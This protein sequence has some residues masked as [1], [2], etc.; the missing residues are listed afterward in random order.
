MRKES[1]TASREE[2]DFQLRFPTVTVCAMR[3]F[4]KMASSP[5]DLPPNHWHPTTGGRDWWA[6]SEGR[7]TT[8]EVDYLWE[9][10]TYSASELVSSIQFD[11]ERGSLVLDSFNSSGGI[12]VATFEGSDGGRLVAA[13]LNSA[14]YGRCVVVRAEADI[15][16]PGNTALIVTLL[17]APA[18]AF[19]SEDGPNRLGVSTDY[20]F[21]DF[22]TMSAGTG[23][24]TVASLAKTVDWSDPVATSCLESLTA[25]GQSRCMEERAKAELRKGEDYCY[26]PQNRFLTEGLPV[27]RT[28]E[29]MSN[30]TASIVGALMAARDRGLCRQTCNFERFRRSLRQKPLVSSN[31][32]ASAGFAMYYGSGLV[33]KSRQLRLY[34][35]NTI[36]AAVGGSMG[37]FLGFSC[38]D[39][40]IRAVDWLVDRGINVQEGC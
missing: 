8:A 37:L 16:R 10:S 20:W 18:I 31:D 38:L 26:L 9:A 15:S 30:T 36:V 6:S 5:L 32:R 17:R 7:L 29:Q 27:C 40:T 12:S 24:E 19:L 23:D 39:F 4:A 14:A 13:E 1:A 25:E 2:E 11:S 33:R 22:R 3:G 21:R 34:D 35:F 28:T